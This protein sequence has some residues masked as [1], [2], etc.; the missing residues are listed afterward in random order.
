MGDRVSIKALLNGGT[1]TF[2]ETFNLPPSDDRVRSL[3]F[4]QQQEESEEVNEMGNVLP[5]DDSPESIDYSGMFESLIDMNDQYIDF[6]TGPF[7]LMQSPNYSE[8]QLD[9]YD[10]SIMSA[11]V[12][13][14]PTPSDTTQN[15]P[16]QA[17]YIS[18][19][20]MAIYNKLWC[21]ALDGKTRQELTACLN[22]LLTADK[23]SRFIP[24]YFRNWHL[25]CPMIHKPSFD[26][27]KAPVALVIG[28]IF[29]GAMYSK[30]QA[31][32]LAA[33]KLVDIA[34]LVVFDGEIFSFEMEI[35]RCLQSDSPAPAPSAASSEEQDWEAFQELQAGFLMV[36]AQYWA[37]PLIPKRRALESRLGDVIKVPT[38][39][40]RGSTV[41]Q[42]L[43]SPFDR[44]KI[45]ISPCA[46]STIRSHIGNGM[47]AEGITYPVW[48]EYLETLSPTD[49]L[50]SVGQSQ[51]LPC[52]TVQ[53]GS[54]RTT[55]VAWPSA[56]TTQIFRARRP[57]S[58]LDILSC[59]TSPSLRR[60][61]PSPKP[62]LSCSKERQHFPVR[63][64]LHWLS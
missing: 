40:F 62:M 9:V 21:L 49:P 58:I 47:A 42:G 14:G 3:Q 8:L 60:G 6:W 30:D 18:A 29:V 38:G 36:V 19:I 52:S 32:R 11:E 23:I 5:V 64:R 51:E 59:R 7:G 54:T 34:E 13:Y 17:Q 45:Q 16:D 31:E 56:N 55:L 24:M 43:T 10:P 35:I 27:S 25:N 4:H 33:K 1:D 39:P 53:G 46:P 41:Q 15:P 26:P 2:T 63:F 48:L 22:F 37:G 12:R 28:V 44:A 57:L 50:S 20:N 61:S